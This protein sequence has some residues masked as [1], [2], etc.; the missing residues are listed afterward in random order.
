MRDGRMWVDHGGLVK[1]VDVT[2]RTTGRGAGSTETLGGTLKA[3]RGSRVQL[4]VTIVAQ[5]VPNWSQFVPRLNRVDVI[6]GKVDPLSAVDDRDTFTAPGTKVVQQWDTSTNLGTFQLTYDLGTLEEA[7]YVRLRG[8]DGN[9]Q[10]P[11]YLGSAVDPAGP[12]IDVVGNGDPWVDLWFYTNPI[13]VLPT[14]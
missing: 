6:R 12:A 3:R 9:R 5:D 11:G 2:V 1:S 14:R 4:V 13:W 7:F 8:T 10:Q